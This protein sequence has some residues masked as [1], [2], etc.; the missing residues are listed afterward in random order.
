LLPG[1]DRIGGE[2]PPVAEGQS[3]QAPHE[4]GEPSRLWPLPVTGR[5]AVRSDFVQSG[6]LRVAPVAATL[7]LEERRARL[8]LTQ[9]QLCDISLPLTV[10]ATPQ[11]FAASARI[12][13]Q[14]QQLEQT[15]H[16]LTD[17]GVLITGDFDL[18]A[19]IKTEGRAGELVRNLK[20]RIRADV[21]D[22]K[23]MKFAL[24]GNILSMGSVD[25]LLEKGG[26]RLD[27]AGFPYR[28]ITASGHFEEGRFIVEESAFQ[29][30]AVGLAATGWVSVIDYQ[31]RLSVLVAPFGRIDRLVRGVPLLGYIIGGALT[32]V[33]VG[34]S[35]DIRD[36][37]VVPLGPGAITSELVGIFERTLK[38]PGKLITPAE[39][40]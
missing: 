5:I 9:A 40:K 7:V 6:R 32:S 23:V 10:E 19:D 22:G 18:Q 25:A 26:P 38:L 12:A 28:T 1:E 2:T 8:D 27:D 20:G 39:T 14:K 37:V 29:S 3:K 17:R 33:P 30:D 35:G 4:K 21:R 24:L 15:A 34:V 16:C 31:S 11:G 36:P 13:A